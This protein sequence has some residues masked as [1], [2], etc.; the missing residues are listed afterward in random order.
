MYV[1]EFEIIK[2]EEY[3]LAFP[4]DFEGGTQGKDEKEIAE[5]AADWLKTEIEHRL[6]H[7]IEIPEAT[8]GN[9]PTDGGRVM[10]VAIDAS[11]DTVNTV[12]AYKA[13]EMLGVS[14][15]RVSQMMSNGLLD[16]FKRGRDAFVTT[17]SIAARKKDTPPAGQPKNSKR[18]YNISLLR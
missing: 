15:G 9:T 5:Q 11:L 18:L 13:A 2:G 17:E 12:P 8:F 6:M 7:E 10:I 14:R 1:Y 3:L 4:F 16:G